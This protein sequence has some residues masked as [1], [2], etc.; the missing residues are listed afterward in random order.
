MLECCLAYIWTSRIQSFKFSHFSFYFYW[1]ILSNFWICLYVSLLL[2]CRFIIH[3]L[4]FTALP[5]WPWSVWD[6]GTLGVWCEGERVGAVTAD[7]GAPRE[8]EHV[9]A[10]AADVGG[11][12]PRP[13]SYSCL[14]FTWVKN[15]EALEI[16]S[17]TIPYCMVSINVY[18]ELILCISEVLNCSIRWTTAR[19]KPMK[20]AHE[21]CKCTQKQ[22][23]KRGCIWQDFSLYLS[24]L[25]IYEQL[26]LL[27]FCFCFYN[28]SYASVK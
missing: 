24:V 20:C 25:C 7:V 3:C 23:L 14:H 5:T 1:H 11:C 9:G 15:R 27:K 19:L 26:F 21:R 18:N 12:A 8:G 6:D 22:W 28:C 4:K 13:W 16:A 10:M 17:P 2:G